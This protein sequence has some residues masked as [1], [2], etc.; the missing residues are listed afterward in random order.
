VYEIRNQEI[1]NGY[2]QLAVMFLHQ[3]NI[4]SKYITREKFSDNYLE[5]VNN[6]KAAIL[7]VIEKYEEMK[8]YS[9]KA[10]R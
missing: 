2:R 4:H 5:R 8:K 3:K 6:L 10:R 9:A 7:M 1:Y